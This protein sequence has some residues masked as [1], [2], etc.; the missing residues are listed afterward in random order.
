MQAQ[1]LLEENDVVIRFPKDLMSKQALSRLLDFI[2][3]SSITEKS[4]M[5]QPQ[6]DELANEV[7]TAVW[8]SLRDKVLK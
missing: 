5:Q 3:F 2:E 4:Q 1:V 8:Q 7:D 6:I